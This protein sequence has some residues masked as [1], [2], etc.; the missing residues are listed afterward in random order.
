MKNIMIERYERKL[1]KR[2]ASFSGSYMNNA[3]WKRLFQALSNNK[4]I[5]KKCLLQDVL[6]DVLREIEI[7]GD[8]DFNKTFNITGINDVMT[9]GPGEFI[10]IEK[11]IFPATWTISRINQEEALS[12]FVYNQDLANIKSIIESIGQFELELDAN[13]LILY[14]YK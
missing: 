11:V 2:L 5:V 8:I 7:P 6:D 3:K 4:V 14:G 12:P 1:E 10:T 13:Q 9:G